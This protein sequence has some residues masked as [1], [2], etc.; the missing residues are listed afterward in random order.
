MKSKAETKDYR[1][2]S[3]EGE[4]PTVYRIH[5]SLPQHFPCSRRQRSSAGG[6]GREERELEWWPMLI[7]SPFPP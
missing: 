4:T 2:S 3:N 5:T 7:F 6:G 1:A